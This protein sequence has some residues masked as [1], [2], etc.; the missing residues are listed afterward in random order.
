MRK[1]EL[2]MNEEFK[3]KIIKKLVETNGNKKRAAI[4]LNRSIRQVDRMI[5]GYKAK[6]KEFFIHGNRGRKPA[7]ALT[8]EEKNEIEQLYQNKYFDCT[9]TAFAEFLAERENINISIDEVR[10]LLRDRYIFSP[11]THKS[12]R[13]RIRKQLALEQKVAKTK[14]EQA[15]IQEKIVAVEDAHPRQPRCQYFGEELQM[16][17]CIHLWFGDK[18]TALHA[19]LDDATGNVLGLY[20]DEQETLNGYYNITY[21]FLTKYGIPYKIKTDKRTVFE[22]KKKASSLVEEDTFTQYAYACKQL[23][24]QI[25]TSSIPEF[26]P[27]IERLFQTLQQRLPQELRLAQINTIQEANQFLTKFID[28]YNKKFALCINN[29]K[30]VFEKQPE[31]PKINLIL[32]ILT[33][34]VVDKGHAIKFKN[35]YYRFTNQHGYPIYFNKGTKCMVIQSFDNQ[36]YATVDNSVFSL[37]E[38]PEVQSK[39]ENFDE[40]EEIKERKVYIPRMIHP[41]KR[42]YFEKFVNN[43]EH[44]LEM[45]S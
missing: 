20:F 21:Q 35:K 17:A 32:A 10:V 38:I 12:T 9:Y 39:S 14:S 33:S 45:I 6:G 7:H 2:R 28:R 8:D 1:V 19:V 16:D 13:K 22:Y 30:S 40:I 29:S 24:I 42:E 44:R 37:E 27:R 31:R 3:Y 11:R 36:M 4:Q 26:K 23:G 34:R 43:Q 5:A 15:I 41:W 18:K 25:E